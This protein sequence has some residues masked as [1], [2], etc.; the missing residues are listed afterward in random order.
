MMGISMW[1][2]W[3]MWGS[4]TL[5]LVAV[6]LSGCGGIPDPPRPTPHPSPAEIAPR[7]LT[8]EPWAPPEITAP[9]P[10][11]PR[12]EWEPPAPAEGALATLIVRPAAGAL[13]ILET[14][15][16][17]DDREIPLVALSGGAYLGLVAAPLGADGIRVEIDAR[18]T[19]GTV[20]H[21]ARTIP[22]APQQFD[23]T[24]LRV[25]SRFTAPDRPT[26]RRIQNE[27]VLV[28]SMLRQ[29][30]DEVLWAGPFRRP[31]SGRTSSEFGQRRVFNGQLRSRHTGLDIAAV[32]GTPIYAANSGRVVLA[33]SL[34]FT[35]NSVYVDHGLGL[36]T[37]YFH[38]SEIDVSQGEWVEKGQR[39]GLVG[40]TGR[41][42]GPH[43]HWGLYLQ[44]IPLDPL[45]LLAPDIAQAS[46][47][48]AGS[49]EATSSAIFGARP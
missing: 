34:F 12:L 39:L 23:S 28:R 6:A 3:T 32:R 18:L 49:P 1:R 25:A 13:P 45:S 40:A 14:R 37:G 30:T 31:I 4:M 17:A 2:R 33:R 26:L 20:T 43:L 35:G 19:D 24:V 46:E 36:H 22:V 10:A 42:T 16:R 38:M 21:V 15:G 8:P 9:R 29:T 47:R 41:V 7:E 44:G 11:P 5:G 27:R 48:L